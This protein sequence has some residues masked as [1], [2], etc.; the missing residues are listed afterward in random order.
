M[1]YVCVIHLPV[2]GSHTRGVVL[3]EPFSKM[4]PPDG[5]AWATWFERMGLNPNEVPLTAS[6]FCDDD[7]RTITYP[8]VAYDERGQAKIDADG[9]LI[10]EDVTI[11]LEAP[12]LP[13]PR[14]WR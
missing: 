10:S 4:H 11:Q 2:F 12:A 9:F 8:V 14:E 1:T 13:F 3:L 6:I 5:E 7:A